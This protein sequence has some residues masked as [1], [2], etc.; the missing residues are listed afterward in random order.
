MISGIYSLFDSETLECLYVGQSKDIDGRYYG[1]L[2][3]L[4]LGTHNRKDFVEWFNIRNKDPESI[5]FCLLEE[6]ENEDS[7]KN[8]LEIK[9]FNELKPRFYGKLPNLN[10]KWEH[11]Q[12]TRNKI[13]NGVTKSLKVNHHQT[14]KLFC[15]NCQKIFEVKYEKRKQKFCSRDCV[16]L[17]NLRAKGKTKTEKEIIEKNSLEI[18]NLYSKNFWSCK[19]IGKKFNISH[20]SISN[21][22]KKSGIIIRDVYG[23]GNTHYSEKSRTMISSQC[24]N[25][26]EIFSRRK[27]GEKS[28]IFCSNSCRAKWNSKNRQF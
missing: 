12:E 21:F 22:L 7:I 5:A 25:C 10:E 1:H 6:C 13:S 9:W 26:E 8:T 15:E 3:S 11:S 27:Q 23:P 4:R 14:V 2:K 28:F 19:K 16:K 24:R 18:M 20:K 17:F